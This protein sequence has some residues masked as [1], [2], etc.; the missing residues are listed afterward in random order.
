MFAITKCCN[1]SSISLVPTRSCKAVIIPFHWEKLFPANW[2]TRLP[3]N[4]APYTSTIVFLV[5]PGNPKGIKDWSDLTKPGVGVITQRDIRNVERLLDRLD[6]EVIR[7]DP[8]PLVGYSDITALNL[9]LWARAGVI[10]A[11]PARRHR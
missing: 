11:A 8:K 4:S 5:R 2:Q 1:T 3:H 7:R 6:F 10:R 9:A